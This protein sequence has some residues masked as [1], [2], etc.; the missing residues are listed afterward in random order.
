MPKN[1]LHGGA[2][3]RAQKFDGVE[4][5]LSRVD[6]AIDGDEDDNAD[7][8]RQQRA[9][10]ALAAGGAVNIWRLKNAGY[11]AQYFVVGI[12]YT[13]LPAT[14]YPFFLGYLSV[15][16]YV[17]ATVVQVS[18]RFCCNTRTPTFC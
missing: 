6:A 1:P 15:P 17:Y 7:E 11:L 2:R 4:A 9:G 8:G 10:D 3:G 14:V 5:A 13:G 18:S 12:I 16:S